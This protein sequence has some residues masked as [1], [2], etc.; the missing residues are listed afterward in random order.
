[1]GIPAGLLFSSI[2]RMVMKKQLIQYLFILILIITPKIGQCTGNPV[3]PIIFIHG[4]IGNDLTFEETMDFLVDKYSMDGVNI[5]DIILNADNNT[6][7]CSLLDVKWENWNYENDDG[8]FYINVG[9]KHFDEE[10]DNF[11]DGWIESHIFAINFKEER[12]EGA[13]GGG[14]ENDLFDESNQSAIV[15]QGYALRKLIEEVLYYTNKEK[16]IL[17]GHSMGGLAIREYLQRTN[18][19]TNNSIH[20]W[21]VNP[22]DSISGHKVAKVVTIGTPHLGSNMLEIPFQN[23]DE[24]INFD[25]RSNFWELNLNSEAIRDLRYNYNIFGLQGR[26]LYGGSENSAEWLTFG[27][28]N[29][30]VNCDGDQDDLIAGI[31]EGENGTTFNSQMHL[32][33]NISYTWITSDDELFIGGDGV[34]DLDR[35]WLYDD[36]EPPNSTPINVSDT[37]LTRRTH[38]TEGSDY[39]SILRGLDEPD[40]MS[41]AFELQQ[42]QL[43]MMEGE[44]LNGFTTYQPYMNSFDTDYFKFTSTSTGI[45]TINFGGVWNSDFQI[46]VYNGNGNIID[47]YNDG[48]TSGQLSFS[49]FNEETY[50]F[51][52]SSVVTSNSYLHPYHFTIDISNDPVQ[53]DYFSYRDMI[54][55]PSGDNDPVVESGEDIDL[56]IEIRNDSYSEQLYYIDAILYTSNSNITI[57]DNDYYYGSFEPRESKMSDYWFDWLSDQSFSGDVYFSLYLEYE[58]GNGALYYETIDLPAIHVY[59]D[60]SIGP[61]FSVI[62][63]QTLYF[64]NNSLGNNDG[65]LQS[66]ENY[67]RYALKLLND[68]TGEAYD[69][70]LQVLESAPFGVGFGDI[71]V[72]YPNLDP[73]ESSYQ[74]QDDTLSINISSSF[75]GQLYLDMDV[76]YNEGDIQTIP[77]V[78]NVV[79]APWINLSQ[80]S[81]NFGQVEP[82]IIETTITIQNQGTAVLT[83]SQMSFDPNITITNLT[84]P[85]D[86]Q[87]GESIEAFIRLNAMDLNGFITKEIIFMSNTHLEQQEIFTMFGTI[88]SGPV[89]EFDLTLLDQFDIKNGEDPNEIYDNPNNLTVGDFDGDGMNEIAIVTDQYYYF[90]HPEW[91]PSFLLIFDFI[92]E[93]WT[94]VYYNNLDGFVDDVNNLSSADL[95]NDGID[96]IVICLNEVLI[97]DFNDNGDYFRANTISG[98]GF[99][100]DG[101]TVGDIDNDNHKE[102]VFFERNYLT[103]SEIFVY[104]QTSGLSFSQIWSSG[105][106]YKYNEPEDLIGRI[107]GLNIADSDNDANNEIL[108]M[109]DEGQVFIYEYVNGNFELSFHLH[110]DAWNSNDSWECYEEC[111]MKVGDTDN[112]GLSELII[113]SEDQNRLYIIETTGNNSYNIDNPIIFENINYRWWIEIGDLNN[114]GFQEIYLFGEAEPWLVVLENFA[115]NSYTQV[116][117]SPSYPFFQHVYRGIIQDLLP[118]NGNHKEL[119]IIDHAFSS[120]FDYIPIFGLSSSSLDLIIPDASLQIEG[121]LEENSNIS[122]HYDIMNF[123]DTHLDNV[124]VKIYDNSPDSSYSNI[125]DEITIPQILGGQTWSDSTLWIPVLEGNYNIHVMIDPDDAIQE[126][127]ESNNI[128]YEEVFITDDDTEGP[129]ITDVYIV[130]YNGNDDGIIE[131]SEEI[132]ISCSVVDASGVNDIQFYVDNILVSLSGED[133]VI[134]GPY[135]EGTHIVSIIAFDNDNSP[136]S[137]VITE[138]FTIR[139]PEPVLGDVNFDGDV[140][141]LDIVLLVDGILTGSSFISEGDLNSDGANDILDIVMLVD[142]ILNPLMEGCTDPNALNYNPE[143]IYD[144]GSC[145]YSCIDIDGN[146]YQT[147]VIGN[148]EWMAENLKVTHYRNGDDILSG[149]TNNEW[150]ELSTGAFGVYDDDPIHAVTYGNLYNLYAVEDDRGICPEE[151]HVPT[152]VDWGQLHDFLVS[153]VGGKLKD[154]GT[155]Q[156]GDGLWNTLNS[157]ATNE[158]GFSALPS[159]MRYGSNGSYISMGTSFNVWSSGNNYDTYF[160][161]VYNLTEFIPTTT[162]LNSGLSVRCVRDAE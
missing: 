114:N 70:E 124:L 12:I 112:D 13:A 97:Y 30:D 19:G 133:Y 45:A 88:Y 7:E 139:V 86:I 129:E 34:V 52:F 95:D 84:T 33:N 140:D 54:I 110:E 4:L 72:D 25:G 118:D 76:E 101:L 119:V 44:Y 106:L 16:V 92:G 49:V 82:G 67:I 56:K 35:Q 91:I 159:G 136:E 102:I 148:Q 41:N 6:T 100:K 155:L 80:Y 158:S 75:S 104:E 36:S 21:W 147:V 64:D 79:P 161:I 162:N 9:R 127:D 38:I 62:D 53:A 105:N 125:L 46:A 43:N 74:I 160:S 3:Y 154:T 107:A 153:Y 73:N 90:G 22:N 98:N 66:G 135:E 128:A 117:S 57:S 32:P 115:D 94:K 130:E 149:Y 11:I 17:V 48:G 93:E 59:E 61:N 122:I 138:S 18:D 50:Y 63:N 96:E 28:N 108:F 146:V 15:K 69:I 134:C 51:S 77:F 71:T 156:A 99:R 141:I 68:G 39:R 144:D 20:S 78:L 123:G 65:I 27:F 26:Y 111:D 150:G 143:A 151:W 60:G 87:P 83:I 109:A 137:T 113:C 2:W 37:L 23:D 103:Q 31:N 142:Y 14:F 58:N 126:E 145:D 81:F 47:Q 121:M 40:E 55:E 8:N 120:P 85:L 5:F 89:L 131:S 1:M 42:S 157:G 152:V 10:E 29:F 132:L 116:Y 24:S